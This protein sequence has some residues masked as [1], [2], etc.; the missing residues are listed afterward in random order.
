MRRSGSLLPLIGAAALL[1]APGNASVTPPKPAIARPQDRSE[2]VRA[3]ATAAL[4]RA[5]ANDCRGALA[6]LDP[7]LPGLP[8]G[9]DRDMVQLLR[10]PCLGPAGR[11][12]EVPKVQAELAVAQPNNGMVRS[13]GIFVAANQNRFDDAGEQLVTLAEQ[14]PDALRMVPGAIWRGISQKLT[15]EDKLTLRNRAYIALARAD[16]QPND[17]PDMRDALAQGAIQALLEQKQVEEARELLPRVTMPELLAGMAMERVYQPIWPDIETRLGPNSGRAVDR[18]ATARL[19]RLAD[20]PDDVHA[21]R[22]GVRAFILL[23]RYAD[24]IEQSAPVKIAVGMD[25]DA[26][27][28]IRYRAQALSALGRRDEAIALLNGFTTLDLSKTPQAVD[29]VVGLAEMLDEAGREADALKVADDALAKARDTLSDYGAMWLARTRACALGAL[30]RT[31]EAATQGDALK[32]KASDNEAAAVEGLLCL[33]RR[34]EAAAIA[35]HA[36]SSI[37]GAS[38]ITDQF[39]PDGAFWAP[40]QSRLRGL[41]VPLLARPDVRT[42]FDKAARILPQSLWPSRTPRDIPGPAPAVQD[43][44][45]VPTT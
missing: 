25:E 29:G 41:W 22:D 33:G 6:K 43:D 10:L 34:D 12:A 44:D 32:A 14:D 37:E 36:L 2:A 35:V 38:N 17:Q 24:A 27:A 23:G 11:A 19:A 39:Q 1:A 21:L 45:S 7:L 5:Q 9:R 42:A 4:E 3:A 20:A 16:W 31:A 40:S 13:F 30:G 18:F 8:S 26:V 15:E 28:V